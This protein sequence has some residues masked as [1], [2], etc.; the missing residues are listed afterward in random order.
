M[1][2]DLNTCKPGQKLKSCHGEILTYMYKNENLFYPHT[3]R[4]QNG[5]YGSRTDD[6]KVSSIKPL[7]SDHNI[8]E[9]L[10]FED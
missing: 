4:Y 7:P 1:K 6:G 10:P 9:I 8:V 2:I 5:G 3:V